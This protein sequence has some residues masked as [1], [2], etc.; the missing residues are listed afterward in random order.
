[1][2]ARKMM[3]QSI[4]IRPQS[5]EIEDRPVPEPGSYEILVRV[6]VCGVC[7]SEL[8]GWKGDNSPYP[9]AYGHE[10]AGEVVAVGTQVQDYSPGMR[11]TGLFSEGFAEYSK[12]QQEFVVPIPEGVTYDEALGEPIACIISGAR[13]TRI[14]LG[15]TVVMVGLGFM[16][17]LMLQ[18]ARLCGPAGII[19]VDPRQD[20]LQTALKSGADAIYTPDEIPDQLKITEWKHLGRMRGSDVVFESS[21]T[22][23]GLSLASE[24]VRDHGI[25]SLVGWHQ[26]GP[27]QVD[28]EMWNWKAFDVVNAHERRMSYLMDCMRRGLALTSAGKLNAAALI[29]HRFRLEEVDQAFQSLVDKPAGFQKAVIVLDPENE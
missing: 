3:K 8:H 29:S 7:A 18:A 13:R 20:V 27:R 19:A 21:G 12:A 10:V 23:Q 25:L 28:M 5:S 17:L 14:E 6:K 9:R 2:N 15:D 26:G 16:G 22:Q 4:I 11:V 1:M 24:L